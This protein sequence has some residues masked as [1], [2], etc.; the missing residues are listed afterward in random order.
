MFVERETIKKAKEKLGNRNAEI[1][2]EILNIPDFDK[3]NLK[4]CCPY[5]SE[6]TP[7]FI[8]NPKN[9]DFH[10]F[11]CGKNVDIIDALMEKGKSFLDAAKYLFEQAGMDYSFGE[12]SVRTKRDYKY[13]HEEQNT[14]KTKVTE[15][16]GKRKISK[17]VIDYLDIR[18]DNNGNCVFNYYDTNDVLTL[19][20]YRPA[21]TI[22]KDTGQP[23]T[24]CQKGADTTPLLFNMNRI[25]TSKPLLITEGECFTGDTE[26]LTP[27]GWIRLDLYKNQDVLQVDEDFYCSYTKPL[28]RIEKFYSGDMYTYNRRGNFSLTTTAKHNWVYVDYKGRVLKRKICDF[29]TNLGN[30]YIPT[31]VFFNGQGIDLSDSYLALWLA[32]SAD[33]TIDERK[34]AHYNYCRIAFKKERKIK[35]FETILNEC[36]LPYKKTKPKANSD[37]A[38]FG[39]KI[40][41]WITKELPQEW[42]NDATLEQRKFIIS[43]MVNWDGNRVSGRNQYE[44]SSK[45]S[46]NAIWMQTMAHTCGYMSTIMERHNKFGRWY[47]VSVLLNKKGVSFQ[48][49]I[50]SIKHYEG[51]VYCVTVPT[52]MI[53]VRQNGHICVCGNCDAASAIEAGHLNT[54]SVPFGAGNFHWIEENWDWLNQFDSIIIWS[55]NDDP[56]LKMRKECLYRLGTWRTK[57][58]ATP[59]YYEKNGK[60]IPIKDINECLQLGG[61]EFVMKLISDAKDIPI[62]SVVD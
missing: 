60:Q 26:I 17:D 47:K 20:K 62:T 30:G 52:G 28:V 61:K 29:P 44:Y 5:H 43:E 46:H 9:Q 39:V 2:A 31:T 24:W 11:G 57:Y 38:F 32:I 42:I 14:D 21:R 50:S 59:P 36:G 27:N 18:E 22:P 7:S 6:K 10:C 15:Y 1:I 49:G 35:R 58:I 19:V 16:L 4:S 33:G 56:G 8:Y 25:N 51:K 3:K 12:Q 54:V 55:D 41:K 23:K 13:P 48:K 34:N 53:L 40:P 45:L 37:Y